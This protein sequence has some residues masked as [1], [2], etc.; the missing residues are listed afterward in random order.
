LNAF[1]EGKCCILFK[2]TKEDGQVNSAVCTSEA[3]SKCEY[4]A[5][6]LLRKVLVDCKRFKD[7]E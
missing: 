7:S 1:D 5:L 2:E 3:N 4:S 6:V